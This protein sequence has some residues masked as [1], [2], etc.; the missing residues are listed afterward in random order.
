[1]SKS[2]SDDAASL[3]IATS[4]NKDSRVFGQAIRNPIH[5]TVF[6]GNGDGTLSSAIS[7]GNDYGWDIAVGDVDGDGDK[8]I[9]SGEYSGTEFI[10]FATTE[11]GLSRKAP[12]QMM[13]S[14]IQLSCVT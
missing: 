3:A 14:M 12:S 2:A 5:A 13:L 4:L 11:W 9:I 6:F 10:S 7:L 1:M 8:D